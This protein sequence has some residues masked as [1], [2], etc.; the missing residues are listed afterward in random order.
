MYEMWQDGNRFGW[1]V[2]RK[3]FGLTVD[4]HSNEIG[5][6]TIGDDGN[7]ASGS[8]TGPLAGQCRARV[9]CDYSGRA[10]KLVGDNGM[11]LKRVD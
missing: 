5:S 7:E 6:G 4:P 3:I 11:A 10:V 9:E 2:A 1:K 8:W